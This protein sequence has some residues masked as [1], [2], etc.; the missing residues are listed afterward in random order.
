M[1]RILTVRETRGNRTRSKEPLYNRCLSIIAWR[2]ER[3]G[4]SMAS[5]WGTRRR[6]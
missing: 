3:R 1:E 6:L 5:D 2:E 4:T